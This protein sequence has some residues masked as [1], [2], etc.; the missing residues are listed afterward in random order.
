MTADENKSTESSGSS[1][2]DEALARRMAKASEVSRRESSD[3][4]L[5]RAGSGSV[6]RFGLV[7]VLL[8]VTITMIVI[9]V[10]GAAK[11]D[12]AVRANLHTIDELR[13]ALG[14]QKVAEQSQTDSEGLR[15]TLTSASTSGADLESIQN[16]MASLDLEAKDPS[17]ALQD[18][19]DL[20]D[21]SRGY[22]T[23]G[24]LT[25]GSFLPHGKWYQPYEPGRD[26]RGKAAWVQ[27]PGDAWS[28]R[29]MPTK[30]VDQ[31]GNVTGVWVATLTGGADDGEMLAWVTGT[32]DSRRAVWFGMSRGLTDLGVKH[33]GAT[34]SSL[35]FD[36]DEGTKIEPAPDAQ[37]LMTEAERAAERSKRSGTSS[38]SATASSSAPEPDSGAGDSAES[39]P[40]RESSDSGDAG[41][42]GMD[43]PGL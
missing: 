29:F 37:S 43:D 1:G 25:G 9:S 21:E 10:G 39:E 27:L 36:G 34:N 16:E 22:F 5:A 18:Y 4:A 8:L 11:H 38:S 31:S 30:S 6:I 19:A 32:F 23:V 13:T 2:V 24:S 14:E 17:G 7:I 35:E 20:V 42:S 3:K 41:D 40:S 26:S 28:W 33:S 15:K 12:D